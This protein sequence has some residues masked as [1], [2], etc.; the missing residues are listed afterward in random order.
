MKTTHLWQEAASF[1]ARAH[2]HQLRKDHVTP[3]FAHPVRVAMT[4]AFVFGV[5]DERVLAAALLH[6]TIEDTTTD[7][8]DIVTGFGPVVAS[9]VVAMTKDMRLP[10]SQRE[11][12]YFAQLA[13][14]PWQGRLI[15]LADT[16]DNLASAW[17]AASRRK[18]VGKAKR[19]LEITQGDARLAKARDR[20]ASLMRQVH[21][22]GRKN[23][24]RARPR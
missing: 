21:G 9:Y 6:D 1:A 22:R 8:E 7:Y 2:Q 24:P 3:Y 23:S 13:A 18:Q 15:K 4:I 11:N 14:G 16:Y 17:D 20:V 12:A 10:E 19:A 5:D